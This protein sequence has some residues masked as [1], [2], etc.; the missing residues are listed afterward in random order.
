MK[1]NFR[2]CGR[3][4]SPESPRSKFTVVGLRDQL[5][6]HTLQ[7]RVYS[8]HVQSAPRNS[9]ELRTPRR[10]RCTNIAWQLTSALSLIVVPSSIANYDNVTWYILVMPRDNS[11]DHWLTWVCT[12]GQNKSPT[13]HIYSSLLSSSD[14]TLPCIG[15]TPNMA[16]VV[17]KATA[18]NSYV[19]QPMHI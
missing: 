13:S 7:L 1:N 3:G 5:T 4:A 12:V 19:R 17:V 10:W 9:T 11:L 6:H 14:R 8:L 2:V 18:Q 16:Q 15:Y